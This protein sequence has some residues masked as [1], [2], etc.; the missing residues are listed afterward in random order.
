MRIANLGGRAKLVVAP[1]AALDI[2]T[3]TGG[4]FG[5]SPQAVY[6][7]WDDFVAFM[8]G[9][10]ALDG[11]TEPW[12]AERSGPPSPTPRQVF[13]VALN[14]R[15]HAAESGFE[16]PPS[17]LF[18]TKF[19]SAF[20]GP[21]SDV[22]LPEGKVDW[23]TELVAVVGRTARRVDPAQ[24]W[25]HVAGLAVGQDLSE[26]VLQRSGPAPQYSLGKSHQ[27]FAPQ[28]PFLVT[29]DELAAPDDLAIGCELNGTP[30][31]AAR[32]SDMIFPVP[33]LISYLSQVVTLLPGDV[34]FTGTPPGVGMG[35][36]P[37]V[38]LRPGDRLVSRIEGIGELH[39][40]FRAAG[41]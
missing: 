24:A 20:S 6:D 11:P 1:E 35:R 32:T 15:D 2:E 5:P 7:R 37:Q 33:D 13:A 10:D 39:Q 21:V 40:T 27:G 26:R 36:D 18:F 16:A 14:Y 9:G 4:R 3:A 19:V 22:V 41:G 25:S 28:G 34:I 17:P 12:S 38:F 31:Q 8:G 29:P 23:E 30:M